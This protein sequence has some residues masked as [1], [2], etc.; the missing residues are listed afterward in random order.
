MRIAVV[1]GNADGR[2]LLERM[3]QDGLKARGDAAGTITYDLRDCM[4][5]P[6]PE[7]VS[8]VFVAVNSML[9]VEAARQIV[10]LNSTAALVVVSS[11]PEYG[12]EAVRLG[13]AHYLLEPLCPAD[14]SEALE[15]CFS[16]S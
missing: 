2:A 4:Q 11:S 10:W 1:D 9:A 13:A 3:L 7:D 14:I 6:L 12:V 15:R 8:A 5:M 16:T